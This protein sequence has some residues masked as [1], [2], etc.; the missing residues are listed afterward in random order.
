M[1]AAILITSIA[2]RHPI[3]PGTRRKKQV[4]YCH[5]Y[6]KV[7]NTTRKFIASVN[8]SC[9]GGQYNPLSATQIKLAQSLITPRREVGVYLV[10]CLTTRF[11]IGL[12]CTVYYLPRELL[13]QNS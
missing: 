5:S 12:C 7:R 2:C 6:L 13:H 10:I 8:C 4:S 9:A 1:S 11:N 3:K